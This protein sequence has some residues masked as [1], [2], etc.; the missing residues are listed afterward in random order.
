MIGRR[1]GLLACL[2]IV[3]A[4]LSAPPADALTRR[5]A[6][7]D[8]VQYATSHGY[9][10]GVAVIDSKTGSSYTGGQADSL[11]VAASVIKV[12]IAVRLLVEGEL[13]GE[14]ER[15]G[16]RMITLSDNDAT[17]ELYPLAGGATLIPWTERHFHVSNLGRPASD[18]AEWGT[19]LLVPRGLAVLYSKL[20]KDAAVA[21]WLLNAMHHIQKYSYVGEYQWWGLPSAT[22][23]AAVKQGWNVALGH[24]NVNTTGFVDRN[25]YAVVIMTRGPTSTYL[26]PITRMITHAAKLLLPDGRFPAPPP[27]VVGLARTASPTAGG[28]LLTVWGSSFTHVTALLFGTHPATSFAIATQRRI[29][30]T[31]PPHAA[32]WVHVRVVTT[33]GVSGPTSANIF[34]FVPPPN[35]T[36]IQ[37]RLGTTSGGNITTVV[38]RHFSRVTKVLFGAAPA[39]SFTVN[40]EQRLTAVLPA[41]AAAWVDVRVLT[42]F[43][44]SPRH[45][46]DR[47]L[48]DDPQPAVTD[49]QAAAAGQAVDLSWSNPTNGGFSAVKICRSTQATPMTSTCSALATVTKPA[50]TFVDSTAGSATTYYYELFAVDSLGQYS[51]GVAVHVTV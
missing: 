32:G 47:Y 44:R 13:T 37:P 16:Y 41:H 23:H 35:V 22:S 30:V 36:G 46:A 29:T 38:G 1:A 31:V 5:Q 42:A 9:R 48:Y 15:L 34:R 8:A 49:A 27:T 43:G 4:V 18:P 17:D 10:I 14:V 7:H 51:P 19:T 25:R 33:H 40:S 12:L 50:A 6:M 24:A 20:A 26:A 2:I 11:F 39:T 45:A 28:R 3:A 21:P